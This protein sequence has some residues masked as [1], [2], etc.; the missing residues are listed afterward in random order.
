MTTETPR[1]QAIVEKGG[2]LV[3]RFKHLVHE[4]NVHS[5]TIKHG[6]RTIAEVPVTFA[7]IG[8]VFA[9][10]VAAAGALTAVLTH[11]A[12]GVERNALEERAPDE[13]M[14][15]ELPAPTPENE[16]VSLTDW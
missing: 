16:A 4:G 10:A 14:P 7:V 6:D 13:V 3:D 15:P 5:V 2:H 1:K 8:A 12:I 9:P 11:C